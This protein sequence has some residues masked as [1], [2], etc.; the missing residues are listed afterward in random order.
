MMVGGYLYISCMCFSVGDENQE[1]G[2]TFCR[3]K[4][5]FA[6]LL[7]RWR[8]AR[9]VLPRSAKEEE[10]KPKFCNQGVSTDFCE[11]QIKQSDEQNSVA[12]LCIIPF[13]WVFSVFPCLNLNVY[14]A[15]QRGF[16]WWWH[17]GKGR[18]QNAQVRTLLCNHDF[19]FSYRLILRLKN[20][21]ACSECLQLF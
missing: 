15:V 8:N 11:A 16:G 19:L 2:V 7:F 17:W 14:V 4:I 9:Q 5:K 12:S 20:F 6:C 21:P 10:S 3:E 13:L 1:H 18:P